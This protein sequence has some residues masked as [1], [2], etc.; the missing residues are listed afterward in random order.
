MQHGKCVTIHYGSIQDCLGEHGDLS[1]EIE[2]KKKIKLEEFVVEDMQEYLQVCCAIGS[3][4][5]NSGPQAIAEQQQQLQQQE[6]Q[7]HNSSNSTRSRRSR[8]SMWSRIRGCSSCSAAVAASR[9]ATVAAF[10]AA[11]TSIFY[12][13]STWHLLYLQEIVNSDIQKIVV[14]QIHRHTSRPWIIILYKLDNYLY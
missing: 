8:R 2:I 14:S 13:G 5:S 1:C 7:L 4:R 10:G 9:A 3:L 11:A 6:Q 12:L